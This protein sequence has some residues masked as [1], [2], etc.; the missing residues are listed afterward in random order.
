MTRIVKSEALPMATRI[1]N[2][3]ESFIDYAMTLMSGS[4]TREEAYTA[5]NVLIKHK[6]VKI[7]VAGGQWSWTHGVFA[8]PLTITNALRLA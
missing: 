4:I 6:A 8:H 7:D 3:E 5:L 1:H 2:A